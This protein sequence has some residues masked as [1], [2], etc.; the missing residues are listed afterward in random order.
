MFRIIASILAVSVTFAFFPAVVSADPLVTAISGISKLQ[1]VA[2]VPLANKTYP[3]YHPQGVKVL[4]SEVYLSTVQ[5]T[6]TGFG[7]VIKFQLDS[8]VA[9]KLAIPVSRVTFDPGPK[10]KMI[11]PGGIDLDGEDLLVPLAEYDS[12]GPG[13]IM[14]VDLSNFGAYSTVHRI[15]DHIGAVV[16]DSD[17]IYVM[18][19]DA[20]KTYAFDGISAK[21]V[22]SSKGTGWNY[23]DCKRVVQGYALCSALKGKVFRN[24]EIHLLYF[25]QKA[26]FGLTL[27]HRIKV[28][29]Y[30]SDGSL[31]G[32][33]PLTNNA[34]DFDLLTDA[35]SGSTT[36]I[37]FYFV[38]H[39]DEKT[40]LMIFDAIF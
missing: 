22:A 21:P 25:S 18:N 36:G 10:K 37:R 1:F 32:A 5:G 9:P 6:S 38:P 40:Q 12:S 35:K 29:K 34:M 23:Q 20:K 4:G 27:V 33:R 19:W 14:R 7:H 39:D 26:P 30:N 28:D 17:S 16:K 2:S 31:G 13:A 3:T 8:A 24:G 11:H 15:K